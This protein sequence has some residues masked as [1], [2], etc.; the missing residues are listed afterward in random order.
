[1]AFEEDLTAFLKTGDF[2][3]TATYDGNRSVVGIF[4]NAHE[5]ASLGLAMQSA[6]R[7]QFLCR[8]DDVDADPVKKRLTVNGVDYRIAEHQPDGTGFALL[9][10]KLA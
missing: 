2:A 4:D 10:L 8:A 7:P 3:V 6:A 1:M 5:L 9:I